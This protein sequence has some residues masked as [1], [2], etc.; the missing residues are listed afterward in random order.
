MRFISRTT[1]CVSLLIPGLLCGEDWRS[2]RG[3]TGDGRATEAEAPTQ[4]G[5]D[6]NI[7]WKAKLPRPGNGSPIVVGDQVL[8]TCAEDAE[9][10]QRSL[11]S[12]SREDGSLRWKR[13]VD[14]E[15]M[16]THKTNPYGGSTPAAT[17]DRV[18]VW[19]ATAGLH[20]YSLDGTPQWKRDLGEYRHVWGYGTS[21][22]IVGDRVIMHCGPGESV[23][24]A[25]F[26]LKDGS[27]LWTHKEPVEGDG[28]RNENN[29]YMGSWSTPVI[30]T[31]NGKQQAICTLPTRL[32]SLDVATGAVLWYCE[33][34]RG[35]KGDLA[36][37]SPLVGEDIAIV[38]GGFNGP[39]F[40]V[41]LGGSGDIT[42]N[43]LWRR[44]KNPQNIGT[45]LLIGEHYYLAN[46]GPGTIQ[47]LEAATGKEVW[48]AR[49]PGVMWGSMILVGDTAY[50]T[51]QKGDTLLFKPNPK[52]FK[53]VRVNRLRET[54]NTT[55]ALADGQLFIRTDNHL[56]CVG[57]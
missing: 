43:R 32:I 28:S 25:A 26:S 4:W 11:Y 16:P 52:E 20:C 9:G 7:A 23:S 34:V 27:T 35:P 19:H 41:R 33:G 49:A 55:P 54:A 3:N 6:E 31:L 10:K 15:K 2:F 48:Q 38:R 17:E 21:P 18:V 47:C 40:A 22:V 36:Y 1:V 24:I 30:R 44:E 50:V 51:S 29:K 5:P 13:T 46:A 57:T 45:G 39:S 53:E 12:F 37:S 56:W 42:D 14:C 8:L